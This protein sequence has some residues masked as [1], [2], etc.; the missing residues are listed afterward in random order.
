[1]DSSEHIWEG[2]VIGVSSGIIL[3]VTAGLFGYVRHRF[4]R[5]TQIRFLRDVI[6]DHR[7]KLSG[8]FSQSATAPDGRVLATGER[9]RTGMVQ[10]FLRTI[11]SALRN[12]CPEMKYDQTN[13]VRTIL[14][15]YEDLMRGGKH[16]PGET[17]TEWLFNR[18]SE[19]KFLKVAPWGKE[20]AEA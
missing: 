11:D 8:D 4:R 2:V 19:V 18:L 16:L 5:L 1:M 6:E 13:Q 14:V 20:P 9:I 15:G 10:E 3:S 17:M 12:R 7:K